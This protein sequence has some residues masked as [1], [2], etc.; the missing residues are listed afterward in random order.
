MEVG[1]V[2]GVVEG[3][4]GAVVVVGDGGI[5]LTEKEQISREKQELPPK[6]KARTPRKTTRKSN[7]GK[8]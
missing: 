1:G 4:G 7:D 6:R 2:V 8:G 3:A 5:N